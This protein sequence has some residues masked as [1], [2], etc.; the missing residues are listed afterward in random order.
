[1]NSFE[2]TKLADE[3]VSA[4]KLPND[5]LVILTYSGQVQFWNNDFK[6][7]KTITLEG[8]DGYNKVFSLCNGN[9]ACIAYK[10]DH[11]RIMI[12]NCQAGTVIKT[13]GLQ[14]DLINSIV[15]LSNNR[16]AAC[17][18]N[19]INIWD[20]KDYN[21]LA[22]FTDRDNY[23]IKALL[24]IEKRNLLI[25]ITVI[26][27]KVW[28]VTNCSPRCVHRIECFINCL[29]LLPN[30]YFA[31]GGRNKNIKIWSSSTFECINELIGAE[32]LTHSISMLEDYRIVSSSGGEINIDY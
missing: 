1:M 11:D 19:R 27:L 25:S 2:Y 16:F 21:C 31:S 6:L 9:L 26:S 24:F 17:S 23:E 29:S 12:I 13:L 5:Q 14:S 10:D 15:N 28:D 3:A 20:V 7:I 4:S 30:G 18:A 32:H 22:S 8:F